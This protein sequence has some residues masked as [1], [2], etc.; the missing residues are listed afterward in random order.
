MQFKSLKTRIA[1]IFLTL[2]LVI[3]IISAVVL[4]NNIQQ[5]ARDTVHSN[6]IVGEKIFLNILQQN[7]ENLSQAA[8]I[9]A[10]DFGFRQAISSHDYETILSAL[11]NY[12]D[13][14]GA[15]V[16]MYSSP[17]GDNI[18]TTTN[19]SKQEAATELA[20]LIK[21]AQAKGDSRQFRIIRSHTYQLVAVPVK[22]PLT[23]GWIVMGFEIDSALA[24]KLNKLTNLEVTFISHS[25]SLD[26]NTQK[27]NKNA[28]V[29]GVNHTK[30]SASLGELVSTDQVDFGTRLLPIFDD[31]H[32]SLV[33]ELKSSVEMAMAPYKALEKNLLILT[34]LSVV[35]F[36]IVIFYVSKR[37]S[38]PITEL[39]EKAK[40]LESGNYKIN[41]K[42]KRVDEIGQLGKAF[43]SMSEAIASREQSISKLAYWDEMTQLPN[44]IAFMQKLKSI[45]SDARN[46]PVS[47]IMMNLN[48][49][50]QINNVLGHTT[51]NEILRVV[52]NRIQ[53]S[54]RNPY[55]PVS[56]SYVARLGGDEFAIIITKTS[57]HLV[58]EM[59]TDLVKYLEA[60]V[61]VSEQLVDISASIGIASYP[62]HA[63]NDEQLLA[64]TEIAM[65]VAKSRQAGVVVFEP[66][67]DASS[68]VNLSLATDLKI[69]ITQHHFQLFVQPKV[70]LKTGEVW[71][72]EALIRWMHPEKGCIFPDQF[73]PF[74]EQTGHIQKISLMMLNLAAGYSALWRSKGIDLPIAVNLSTRDLID[75]N[76]SKKIMAILKT[77]HLN[78]DALSLEITES[79]IM[80]DPQRALQTLE[81]LAGIGFKLSIDDFGTGYSSLAYLKK[82][83]VSELKIDKSFVLKMT[84]DRDDIKIVR[85]TIDL[86]HNFNLKVVAEGIENMESWDLLKYLGCD[87][88]QGY[89]ISRPMPA[90]KFVSWLDEWKAKAHKTAA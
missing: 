64:R 14:I 58:L 42:N 76:L 43:N 5:N 69:A 6:L 73:I 77:H 60:P 15:N 72:L 3:Q 34:I 89:F 35:V 36:T 87:F 86:A 52:A 13:R 45:M 40:Q 8:K 59:V 20:A 9:L 41:I 24:K 21:E 80:D 50:K 7:G 65:Q 4:R 71:S 63:E 68:K 31:G 22:A 57:T 85:S 51:A 12:Q 26:K 62:E 39:A 1:F 11:N 67:F 18:V 48:R 16:A 84:E 29:Q 49:F 2:M 56:I 44:R 28:V 55:S 30:D 75:Q 66:S 47:V 81:E 23:I 46:E 19:V 54:A 27:L 25:P 82:L 38:S 32:Q 78:T 61:E 70:N 90:D 33:V 17:N 10:A 53:E 83:P 37:L 74:A 79:A 88:G